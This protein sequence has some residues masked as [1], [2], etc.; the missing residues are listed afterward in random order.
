[1]EDRE[2][3]VNG[4][5]L[6]YH[7]GGS[8]PPLVLLHG[9]PQTSF[10]WRKVISLLAANYTV[11]A[12]DL[13]GH[14]QSDKPAEG[15]E[16]HVMAEDVR[17]LV[18]R[19]GL[20]NVNMVGHDLGG[21][22]AYVYAAQHSSEVRRLGIMEAPIFGVPSPKMEEVLASYWHLG[23]YAHPKL[24]ELLLA[25]R[26]RA[27]LAEF[28]R[29]YQGVAGVDDEAIDEYARHLVSADGLRGMLGVYRVIA[30]EVPAIVQLTTRRLPMPV[31][32]VGGDHSMGM[33]P[34]EQFQR[35]AETV[36]GGVI[37][38]CGHWVAEEQPAQVI[39]ELTEFLR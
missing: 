36:H 3:H 2:Q 38:N 39:S 21:M 13:R 4:V 24:P 22:V 18:I 32:A 26:E 23:F 14:G 34:F 30:N 5:R 31:W 37:S 12:P 20:E 1:M 33:G 15:Y 17:Q 9:S 8:G 35:L 10:A 29:T 28:I 19:L 7:I 11:V 27:Y 25:G 16:V 6:H